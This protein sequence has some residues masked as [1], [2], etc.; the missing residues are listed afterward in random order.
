MTNHIHFIIG[1]NKDN[2][3]DIIRDFKKFTATKI[4]EAIE[5]NPKDSRKNWMLWLLK[6]EES[7]LFW[8]EG[9]HA[10]EIIELKFFNIKQDYIHFNPVRAGLVEKEEDYLYSSCGQIYGVRE[11]LLELVNFG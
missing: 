7:I 6:K 9:Y 5:A 11:G 8:Q 3:S 2:L 1:T 10:E 4:T